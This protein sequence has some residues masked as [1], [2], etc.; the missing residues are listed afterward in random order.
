MDSNCNIIKYYDVVIRVIIYIYISCLILVL[1]GKCIFIDF[2]CILIIVFKNIWW[3]NVYLKDVV[4]YG[5]S[6]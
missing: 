1:L 2:V 3:R 4:K 5:Y 6:E